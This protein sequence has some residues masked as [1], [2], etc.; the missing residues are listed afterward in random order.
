MNR[1]G[2]GGGGREYAFLGSYEMKK[3]MFPTHWIPVLIKCLLSNKCRHSH[4]GLAQW[5]PRQGTFLFKERG[6]GVEVVLSRAWPH[7]N[8]RSPVSFLTPGL[9]QHDS[10]SQHLLPRFCCLDC[11][12]REKSGK[13]EDYFRV[14]SPAISDFLSETLCN[15]RPEGPA[16]C[17][18]VIPKLASAAKEPIRHWMA[19]ATLDLSTPAGT[20]CTT[21]GTGLGFLPLSSPSS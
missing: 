1:V 7:Y 9:P 19:P 18:K 13:Q 3:S 2:M 5:C 14:K 6:M 15:S 16:P 17:R 10:H 4:L 12:G 11:T 8:N 20:S 21:L